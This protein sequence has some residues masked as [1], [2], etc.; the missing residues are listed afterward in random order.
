MMTNL[1]DLIKVSRP[2]FWILWPVVFLVGLTSSGSAMTYLAIIQMV[3][4]SFP[5]CLVVYGINDIFDYRSDRM[6]P[7]KKD[8]EGVKLEKRHFPGIIYASAA[9]LSI[10]FLVTVLTLN[11]SN[12]FSSFLFMAIGYF[13]SAPPRLKSIPMLD[14]LSNGI[15]YF[16]SPFLMGF[17]YGSDIASVGLKWYLITFCVAGIHAFTTIMDHSVDK[18]AGDMTFSVFFGKR[19][20]ALFSFTAFAAASVF[21]DVKL[22]TRIYLI[23]CAAIMLVMLI[24]PKEELSRFF[25]KVIM[26]GFIL[27]AAISMI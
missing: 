8:I 5:A 11:I 6:N 2:A 26:I 4:L 27:T 21:A 16:Y 3:L 9:V 20:A 25:A 10:F 7:R 17:S 12:L 14:S 15:L 13:Y 1:Y 24:W 22:T 18:K 23:F 19:S